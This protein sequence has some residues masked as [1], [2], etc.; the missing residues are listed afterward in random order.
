[1]YKH[2]LF[3]TVLS[4][5]KLLT[6]NHAHAFAEGDYILDIELPLIRPKTALK[7]AHH[8]KSYNLLTSRLV[9]LT[10][11]D[12]IILFNLLTATLSNNEQR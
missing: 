3:Y 12:V 6:N 4:N 9:D 7:G 11:K 8:N 1:M 2:L 5:I 10:E